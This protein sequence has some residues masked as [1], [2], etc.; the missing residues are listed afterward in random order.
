[1][2]EYKTTEEFDI[3]AGLGEYEY[4]FFTINDEDDFWTLINH[5]AAVYKRFDYFY[6]NYKTVKNNNRLSP[7]VQ[8]KMKEYNANLCL[9]LVE[10]KFNEND[11]C[12]RKMVVNEQKPKGI[13]DT[14]FFH[15][16]HFAEARARDY[17]NRGDAYA[18]SGLHDAA[19]RHLS[20][21]IKLDPS[22]GFAFSCR[23]ASYLY[24][25]N[26]DNAIEDF[27]QAI[28][29]NT[30][31]SEIFGLRGFAYKEAGDFDKAKA[32]FAKALELNPSDEMAKECLEE[33]IKRNSEN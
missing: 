29:L 16:Y 10:E 27:T 25:K 32:D 13:Y 17:L 33:L 14:Y 7:V 22:I 4:D 20:L 9:T 30:D 18:K 12:I 23:G 2:F 6:D 15:F 5:Y 21:A 3:G 28:N 8:A 1:M 24:T 31:H 26:Y 11:V 19:I